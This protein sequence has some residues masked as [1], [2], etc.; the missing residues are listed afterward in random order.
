MTLKSWKFQTR[1]KEQY[2]ANIERQKVWEEERKREQAKWNARE[3][4]WKERSQRELQEREWGW[5]KE[6]EKKKG[7]GREHKWE[8][9]TRSKN[10][11]P[12]GGPKIPHNLGQH[13]RQMQYQYQ[14]QNP[15]WNNRMG[16]PSPR[17]K[18]PSQRGRGGNL[19]NIPQG[20]HVRV[21]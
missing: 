14:D 12:N 2:Q 18:Q 20:G 15:Q 6:L 13:P 16:C 3:K 8:W 19:G 7:G 11:V 1:E 4:A 17:D 21:K 10:R 5:A 9:E